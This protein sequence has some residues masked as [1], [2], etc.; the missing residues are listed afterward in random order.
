MKKNAYIEKL[1]QTEGV[2]SVMKFHRFQNNLMKYLD[3]K[4]FSRVYEVGLVGASGKAIWEE[5]VYETKQ[6]FYLDVTFSNSEEDFGLTIYYRPEKFQELIY[7][8]TQLLKPFKD[9]RD[10]NTTAEGE[11]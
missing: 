10:N 4:N 2:L 6:K 3:E 5:V 11:N 8:T 1:E 9:A 7:F